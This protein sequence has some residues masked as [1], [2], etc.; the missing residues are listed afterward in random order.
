MNEDYFKYMIEVAKK[1]PL[2]WKPSY[3]VSFGFSHR[4][5]M[6]EMFLKT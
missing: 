4:L 1:I 3:L 6:S 5:L 2:T